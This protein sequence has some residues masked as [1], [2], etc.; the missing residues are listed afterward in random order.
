MTSS[1]PYLNPSRILWD[2]SPPR[3]KVTMW[4][5]IKE[6]LMSTKV[7]IEENEDDKID[8]GVVKKQSEVWVWNDEVYATYAKAAAASLREKI[9]IPL[10]RLYFKRSGYSTAQINS[11]MK[12]TKINK[13]T[14]VYLDD[15][16]DMLPSLIE[17]LAASKTFA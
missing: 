16:I 6:I 7:V 17:E 15:L 10:L 13:N 12:S 5:N 4:D 8:F 3:V 11:Q 14:M 2:T 9:G 1:S